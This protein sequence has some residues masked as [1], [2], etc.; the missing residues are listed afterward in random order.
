MQ[1]VN[2][3]IYVLLKKFKFPIN[4]VEKII[5][6]LKQKFIISDLNIQTLDQTIKITT[7]YGFSFWDSMMIAA[8]PD[9][10]G[11]ILYTEDM[12]N[13]QLI[14]TRLRIINPFI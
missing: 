10:H 11:S 13:N 9:N 2:E 14:E 4:D 7:Q 12:N 3:C 8:A 6:F 1:V 5:S